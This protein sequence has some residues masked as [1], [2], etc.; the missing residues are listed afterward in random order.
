MV[1]APEATPQ[2]KANLNHMANVYAQHVRLKWN[3][4]LNNEAF[5]QLPPDMQFEAV[6]IGTLTGL[7]W[8]LL[9]L[10]PRDKHNQVIESTQAYVP[11]AAEQALHALDTE[12]R[13][14]NKP[15]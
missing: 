8:I 15:Q 5:K 13:G 4:E 11:F 12:A 10:T 6:A 9:E 2:E 1:E 3:E 7:L 14:G